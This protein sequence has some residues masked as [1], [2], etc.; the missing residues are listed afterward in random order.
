MFA[1]KGRAPAKEAL[2][3]LQLQ[4]C[5]LLFTG[6]RDEL[7]ETLGKTANCHA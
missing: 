1:H 5:G 7:A 4:K 2:A 6:Q 3:F